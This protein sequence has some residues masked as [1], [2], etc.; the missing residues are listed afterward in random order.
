MSD[1]NSNTILQKIS[2]GKATPKVNATK[3]SARPTQKSILAGIVRKRTANE[4]LDGSSNKSTSTDIPVKESKAT[5]MHAVTTTQSVDVTD[6]NVSSTTAG[7]NNEGALKCIGILP[8]IGK[9]EDSSDS[10]RSTD[11]DDEYDFRDYDWIGRKIKKNDGQ[12]NE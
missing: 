10:D 4:A 9:Y 12:C 3:T 6:S 8:G 7:V 11:T 2:T 5:E 1:S